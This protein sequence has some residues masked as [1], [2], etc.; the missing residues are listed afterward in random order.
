MTIDLVNSL[1]F[2][3][4]IFI[5]FIGF[6]LLLKFW[7]WLPVILLPLIWYL[8]SWTSPGGPL[9]HIR[10]IRWFMILIIPF[11]Y[12]IQLGRNIK[13]RQRLEL[14]II[15][16]PLLALS[17]VA[18][19]SAMLNASGFINMLGYLA[20]FLQYPLFFVILMN[21]E[22][23]DTVV[24]WFI[25][26]F[27]FLTFIQVPE[28]I[29]RYLTMGI[30]GDT[31]SLTLGIYGHYNIGIFSLYTI[32]LI[33]AHSL[34]AGF[35]PLYI[36]ACLLLL[37]CSLIGE[38]KIVVISAPVIIIVIVFL[39]LNKQLSQDLD[40][41]R[42]VNKFIIGLLS[43]ALLLPIYTSWGKVQ[44]GQRNSLG[45]FFDNI[46]GVISGTKQFTRKQIYDINRIGVFVEVWDVLKNNSIRLL[47]G[48]G[49]GSTFAGNFF[50][51]PGRFFA[52][53][54]KLKAAGGKMLPQIPATL[55]DV[56]FIGLLVYFWIYA[57]LFKCLVSSYLH[58]K[59]RFYE[60]LILG[61][62]GIWVFYVILGPIY[63]IVWRSEM[64]S[65][66]FYFFMAVACRQKARSDDAQG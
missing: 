46:Y 49:P 48:Y 18:V 37:L 61:S 39:F 6:V 44:S 28:I 5:G 50:G 7:E 60:I 59:D 63:N 56:G 19:L 1:F 33:T 20:L 31:V 9:V 52:G 66:L 42:Y 57:L 55:G 14:T 36:M 53:V 23:S 64:A 34:T 38:I 16:R 65:Y 41:S 29:F 26:L 32:A 40:I 45:R 24:V 13:F 10:I 58:A 17:F 11:L 54:M 21:I 43:I 2:V 47:F 15:A 30:V 51:T 4:I 3:N 25:K 62:F 8:P 35:S 22:L 27:L 12:I